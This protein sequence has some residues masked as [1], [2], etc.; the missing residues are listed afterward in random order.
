MSIMRRVVER[1]AQVLP[2]RE[3]D[4]LRSGHRYLGQ[5]VDRL[6]GV[7]KVTGEARFS[8]EYPVDGPGARRDRLQHDPERR[9]HAHRYHRGGTGARRHQGLHPSQRAADEGAGAVV[10][11]KASRRRA[12]RP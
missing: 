10:R 6:D 11:R 8:A 5:P 12:H 9:H 2:D 1:I 7:D 3:Q 4:E